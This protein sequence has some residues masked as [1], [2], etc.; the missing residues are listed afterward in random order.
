MNGKT[1]LADHWQIAATGY[2][3]D[4]RQH[5]LDGNDADFE[6]CSVRSSF[7]GAICL[8]DDAFGT[9]PGG[10][11]TAFRDQFVIVNDAGQAFPFT[12]GVTYG[13]VD[14]T[15]TEATTE[16]GALQVTSDAPLLGQRNYLTF[17]ATIDH[18]DIG[19]RSTST[20][21]RLYPD[22]RVDLDAA[23]PG[24]GNVVHTRGDLGYAPVDLGGTVDYYG[25]YAV[26][27][28]NLSDALTFTAGF[29]VNVADIRTHDRT[30]T[31]PELDGSH[32]FT[33]VNPL[34]GVTYAISDEISAFGGY[35]EGNRAPTLLELDCAS[36]TQPC[37]LEGSLVADP[38][39]K[40]VV[41]HT[42]EA[43]FAAAPIG[44]AAV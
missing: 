14:R 21:G 3:R 34:A 39:L 28:L 33:R 42:Y 12:G 1:S 37:L 20:L 38:P 31:A 35:S 2:V 43:V 5:H 18:S 19:F 16:G 23:L 24:S 4:F 15:L 29:R 40:Q 10:K 11:T 27:A 30:G 36:E 13:T 41:S 32:R 22:L 25:V 26:D 8:E 17:G 7:S 44:T 6:S 9:P